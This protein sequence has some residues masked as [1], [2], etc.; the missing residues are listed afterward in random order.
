MPLADLPTRRLGPLTVAAQG[1][2]CLSMSSFYGASD[3]AEAIATVH[4]AIDRGVAML[5]TADIQG[6]L[7]GEG[8]W[9]LGTAVAG[10]RD[11]VLIATKAGLER[12]H[13][14]EFLGV[15][16]DRD[17]LRRQCDESLRRLGI[18]HIDLYTKH[19]FAPGEDVAETMGAL[20]ELVAAGKV[21][22]VC[23]AEVGADTIRRAHSVFPVT[24]VQ[25]EWSL[26]SRDI[27]TD[28]VGTCRELGIGIVAC[29][30]LG[31]GF[32]AGQVADPGRPEDFRHTLPRFSADN[33]PRNLAI[34][35]RL[36]PPARRH[37]L[38]LAQL[39]LAWVHHQGDDVVPIPGTA[40]R[41]HLAENLA[42][43]LVELS[44]AELAEIEAAVAP[45]DVYG[46]RYAPF[47]MELV[48][49]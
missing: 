14:G 37:G 2:G 28:I 16:G 29:C 24:A 12:S 46:E 10:R 39:A 18:D 8:E 11:E 48:G 15:R 40:R 38:T 44:P 6:L 41:D 42:A 17:Y 23:L 36:R 4:E 32:L 20:G 35:E 22:H 3:R 13:T 5:D 31:R 43:A 33:L 45:G 30:P 27:E 21:R 47:L 7:P 25:S 34:L 49:N 9:V 19:W 26:W 1:L